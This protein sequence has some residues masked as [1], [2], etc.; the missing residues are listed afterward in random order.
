MYSSSRELKLTAK[1]RI[2]ARVF[3]ILVTAAIYIVADYMIN[4]FSSELSG[5]NA[6]TRR[7][8]E[9]ISTYAGELQT[10][11]DPTA[12]NDLIQRITG[13]LPTFHEFMT[14]RGLM[15]PIL[16]I[17]VSLISV[18]LSVGYSYHVL[19]ESRGTVTSPG[20]LMHGFKMTFKSLGIYLLSGILV[21][22]GSLL[23]LVPGLILAA[24]YSMAFFVLLDNPE[25]G[26]VECMRASGRIMRGHKWRYWCLQLSFILWL[27]AVSLVT[28]L[29]GA[30]LLNI[31]VMPYIQ[32]STAGFYNELVGYKREPVEAVEM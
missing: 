4:W 9:I 15:G 21:M 20:S 32:L 25:N 18:P 19:C 22:L 30:P 8:A 13:A 24:R 29:I 28:T 14:G 16:S 17:L 7:L 11:T 26:P 6:Y 3:P 1:S 31:Y 2:R 27:I 5:Y 12:L 10:M 23:F